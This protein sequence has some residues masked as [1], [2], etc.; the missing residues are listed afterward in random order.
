MLKI[1]LQLYPLAG[2]RLKVKISAELLIFVTTFRG[3]FNI[4]E[5][6]WVIVPYEVY[7]Q[8]ALVRTWNVHNY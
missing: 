2:V 5:T 6:G 3:F 7:P 4:Q 1:E 8:A